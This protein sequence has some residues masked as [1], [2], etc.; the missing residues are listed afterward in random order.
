MCLE[1]RSHLDKLLID[2]QK[3]SDS[4]EVLE[5][6]IQSLH[7]VLSK[8]LVLNKHKVEMIFKGSLVIKKDE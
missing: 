5:G 7:D 2:M 8:I 3:D 4:I 6:N 1:I